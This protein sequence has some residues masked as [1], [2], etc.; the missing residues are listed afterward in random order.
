MADNI[1]G[2]LFGVDPQQIAQQRQTQ[3]FSNAFR[4]AQL[5]PLQQ[6][7]MSIY[8]G[9]SG[10]T[11]GVTGLLGGDP[12]MEKMSAI[13]QLS[14]QFD[15]TKPQGLRDFAVALQPIAPKEAMMAAAEADKR[16]QTG[17]G[18]QKTR[19]DVA[20]SELTAANEEKLRG[21]LAA[22]GPNPSEQQ[23]IA[24]VQKYGS[25][26]KIL[27]ILTASQDRQAALAARRA[28]GGGEGGIGMPGPV[29][30]SGAY[31]D[32][33]GQILGPTEMKPVRQEFEA[34]QRL[35]KTLN[36][37]SETDVKN[38][39][40][41][42]DWTTKAESKAL[43]SQK[44]LDA[45]S[46]I[47][48]SQLLEQIGQL[49]PGSASDADMRAAMKNFPGYTDPVALANWVNR[50]K[51]RLQFNINRSSDQFGFKP[52]IT[53]TA[54]L[55]LGKKQGAKS[56]QTSDNDLINKYLNPKK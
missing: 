53:T 38:A 1:V 49:P 13:K 48:A 46:K 15:L 14:S 17:L 34:N 27:Q 18:L 4:Y 54:P 56:T 9:A 26:D 7:K 44:T 33:S 12:E 47:A 42:V 22:L 11:R 41:Y 29:G 24:V 40:S 30:K 5:D 37:V 6:A 21:E 3:D 39:E 16:E 23:V 45:Q 43:A 10:L 52:T 19:A 50:T 31:R 55:D 20:R 35:L 8:Q 28:A 36:D 2:G 51:E 32:I 25:P